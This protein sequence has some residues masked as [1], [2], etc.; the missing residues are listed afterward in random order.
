MIP[1]AAVVGSHRLANFGLGIHANFAIFYK[2]LGRRL[3]VTTVFDQLIGRELGLH[4]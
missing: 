1:I 3:R 4:R 2:G